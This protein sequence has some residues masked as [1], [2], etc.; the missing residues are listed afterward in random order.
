MPGNIVVQKVGCKLVVKAG[1]HVA[2]FEEQLVVALLPRQQVEIQPV[3]G[4]GI[5]GLVQSLIVAC[6]QKEKRWILNVITGPALADK[7]E[8]YLSIRI[9]LLIMQGLGKTNR[10]LLQ[11]RRFR[12][13]VEHH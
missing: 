6:L 2:H 7:V 1:I 9:F 4:H 10:S 11:K 12:I 8:Y 5:H 3:Q 13:F